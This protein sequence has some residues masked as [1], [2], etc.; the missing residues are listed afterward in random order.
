MPD[1]PVVVN[2]RYEI[3]GDW[4]MRG[5]LSSATTKFFFWFAAL[6]SRLGLKAPNHF[7]SIVDA[8]CAKTLRP[9]LTPGIVA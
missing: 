6:S 3:N 7:F 5:Y 9:R 8:S 2:F 4:M 1:E